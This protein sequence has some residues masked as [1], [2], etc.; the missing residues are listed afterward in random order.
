MPLLRD[1]GTKIVNLPCALIRALNA[2]EDKL[3]CTWGR[4]VPN[5]VVFLWFALLAA[6]CFYFHE[7]WRDET[8][9]WLMARDM[10]LSELF[11]NAAF[12]GHPIGWHVVIKPLTLMGWPFLSLRIFN[13]ILVLGAAAV[14]LWKSPF[15]VWQKAILVTSPPFIMCCVYSRSYTL[16][17]L[18][19]MLQAWFHRDRMERP[20]RY[21]LS[22]GMLANTLVL[23]LPY[24]AVMGAW[25][26]WEAWT[27][28]RSWRVMAS[29][30]LLL[31]L[32]LLAVVQVIPAPGKAEVMLLERWMQALV[33]FSKLDSG[34]KWNCIV[35]LFFL[36][37]LGISMYRHVPVVLVAVGFSAFFALFIHFFIYPLFYRHYFTM[38]V[39]LYASMWIIVVVNNL[40]YM[41][42]CNFLI[43]IFFIFSSY[44]CQRTP[45][46][47]KNEIVKISSN[48]GFA[49][50]YVQRHFLDKPVA[51]HYMSHACSLLAYMPGKRF[52]NPASK[53][54][55]TFIVFDMSWHLYGEMPLMDALERIFRDCPEQRPVLILS[56]RWPDPRS[57][58]YELTFAS[59]YRSYFNEE[60]FVYVPREGMTPDM[61]ALSPD[62][63][64][65]KSRM[66][67]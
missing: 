5:L 8:Q 33:E 45:I 53:K 10:N 51:A 18:G 52:W 63:S 19:L 43:I 61:V 35:P 20:L 44:L 49:V 29:I 42:K 6:V 39:I 1:V 54:W 59:D 67:L 58:R 47:I 34:E 23:C 9:S 3:V 50:D 41:V 26:L 57:R 30:A 17:L 12:E 48:T 14:L 56:K 36:I 65:K 32:G 22:L 28:R 24:A 37:P 11:R 7:P 64:R 60:I 40:K 66:G 46:I 62:F 13:T 21:A 55:N 25:W 16:V 2:L 27:T 38:L 15:R 4:F 31:S